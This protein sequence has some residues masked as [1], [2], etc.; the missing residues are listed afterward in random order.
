MRLLVALLA[1]GCATPTVQPYGP[2]SYATHAYGTPA[3]ARAAVV[4][5]ASRFCGAMGQRSLPLIPVLAVGPAGRYSVTLV[6]L[7]FE[8]ATREAT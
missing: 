3:G 1:L 6:F 2:D 5:V 8:V 4:D 7:C